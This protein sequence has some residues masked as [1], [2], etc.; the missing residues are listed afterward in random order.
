MKTAISGHNTSAVTGT[1]NGTGTHGAFWDKREV[2]S[3]PL[4]VVPVPEDTLVSVPLKVVPVPLK[5]VLVPN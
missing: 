5:V 2:V 4:K 3:V 1:T